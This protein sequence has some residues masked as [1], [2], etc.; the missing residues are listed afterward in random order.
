MNIIIILFV[1]WVGFYTVHSARQRMGHYKELVDP[2][3]GVRQPCYIVVKHSFH[4]C[5]DL[6]CNCHDEQNFR[7]DLLCTARG[8]GKQRAKTRFENGSQTQ[9]QWI[10]G[11]ERI[12]K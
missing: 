2:G 1:V 11:R 8:K 4:F 3:D 6:L 7:Y 12:Q 9:R 10:V 5:R